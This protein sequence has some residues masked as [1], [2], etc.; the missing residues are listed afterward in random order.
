MMQVGNGIC[1]SKTISVRRLLCGNSQPC[2]AVDPSTSEFR[3]HIFRQQALSIIEDMTSQPLEERLVE[4][5][6]I[7]GLSRDQAITLLNVRR[8]SSSFR[9]P[10][11]F[12]DRIA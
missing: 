2:D 10:E 11:D 12:T 5:T 9:L 6:S 1:T 3:S 7:T 4:I 8:A